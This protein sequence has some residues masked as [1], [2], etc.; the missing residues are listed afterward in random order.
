MVIN[1]YPK[2]LTKGIQMN[3][4]SGAIRLHSHNEYQL[5]GAHITHL[6][7]LLESHFFGHISLDQLIPLLSSH[8]P[9]PQA[10]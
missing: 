8:P 1:R 4:K 5:F 10:L 3:L 9:D 2:E 6:P 7:P